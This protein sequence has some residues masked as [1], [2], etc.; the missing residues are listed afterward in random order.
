MFLWK[1]KALICLLAGS[2]GGVF[3]I[4][5]MISLCVL[6]VT[7][8]GSEIRSFSNLNQETFEGYF[9]LQGLCCGRC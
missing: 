5:V 7:M 6:T 4:G 3:G 9:P 8:E 1:P 2:S